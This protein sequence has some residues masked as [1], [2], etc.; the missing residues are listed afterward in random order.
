MAINKSAEDYLESM[1]ILKEKNGY[2]RSVDIARFLDVT[3]PSVS[4]ATKHLK[5]SG[6]ITMGADGLITL[7]ESGMDIAKTIY[8]RHKTLTEF[9][10]S[11]G[12]SPETAR[13]DAC[14]LEHDI[15]EESF[16]AL[17]KFAGMARDK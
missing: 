8:E 1:L 14:L 10:I 2:I 4:Y 17:C 12:V 9:F 15:S 3:K 11:I 16:D 6:H 13:K 5:E 7:T